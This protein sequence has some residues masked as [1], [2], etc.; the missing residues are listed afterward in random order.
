MAL[1]V[2]TANA[3]KLREFRDLLAG[4]EVTSPAALGLSL[5]VE[6]T[7]ASF[8]AN[9]RLKAAAFAA[10]AGAVTLA[11][12]SGLEVDRL[13]GAPGVH[14]ARYGGEGL[15]DAGRCRLLLQ[16]LAGWP[17]PAERTARFRCVLVAAAPDGRC[18]QAEGV[19]EGRIAA[20]PR[21][22]GGFGY[23]PLFHLPDHGCTMAELAP[24]EK[25]RISHRGQA[26]R[27]LRPRLLATFPELRR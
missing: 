23:D 15:D 16:A 3:G 8:E 27:A 21:G 2:A 4:I 19:C 13:G 22:E 14:S 25:S 5:R 6:E 1:L 11:D 12:D 24:G 20:A 18:C 7:G 9:A 10:A 17:D 26:L